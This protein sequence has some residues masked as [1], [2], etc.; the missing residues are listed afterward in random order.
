MSST[1]I[2]APRKP[3][4]FKK[5]DRAQW[6]VVHALYERL[7]M[8]QE[9]LAQYDNGIVIPAERRAQ[10]RGRE[11]SERQR[12]LHRRRRDSLNAKMSTIKQQI[13]DILEAAGMVVQRVT[14]T[15]LITPDPEEEP[16]EIQR[17]LNRIESHPP[18]S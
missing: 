14:V 10:Q 11:I 12:A 9:F 1:P 17:R 6:R 13:C 5:L 18:G 4:Y 3:K 2:E 8:L 15:D 7:L 16:P